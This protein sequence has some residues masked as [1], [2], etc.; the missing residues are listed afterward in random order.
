MSRLFWPGERGRGALSRP[1]VLPVLEACHGDNTAGEAVSLAPVR[2]VEDHIV[3]C[4]H[5]CTSIAR[6]YL[7]FVRICT[8]VF[9][10][11]ERAVKKRCCAQPYC[12][13]DSRGLHA[14][15]PVVTCYVEGKVTV[16]GA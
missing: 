9:M 5:V 13:N 11:V 10:I 1:R 6:G 16:A 3:D 15:V 8:D 7:S 14:A 12:T 2:N 4:F